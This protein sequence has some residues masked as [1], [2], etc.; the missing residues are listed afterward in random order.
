MLAVSD[1]GIGIDECDVRADVRAVLHDEAAGE[2]TGLGLSTVHGIVAQ[3]GGN[4]WVYSEPGHGTAFRVYIPVATDSA[5]LLDPP[6]EAALPTRREPAGE[7]IMLVEDHEAV[8]ALS[9]QV[10]EAAG[11]DVVVAGSVDAATELLSRHSVDLVLTD[12]V[13][14]GGTGERIAESRDVRGVQPPDPLHVG[15]HRGCRV[16]RRP[17]LRRWVS[18]EAVHAGCA[19]VGGCGGFR[20]ELGESA[21]RFKGQN[22]R[23]REAHRLRQW[24]KLGSGPSIPVATR[25]S[26]VIG[27]VGS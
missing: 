17:A 18:R 11:Y 7:T 5:L 26:P 27:R 12:L 14:P 13:M 23:A 15:L 1:T 6:L 24:P 19:A 10:L 8:L 21:R 3:S 9:R 16:T 25:G 4:I 2:G 22:A 20:R